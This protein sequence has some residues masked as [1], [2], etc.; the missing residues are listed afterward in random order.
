MAWPPSSP[1][2]EPILPCL[3]S[4]LI[5]SSA[6]RQRQPI[7]ILRDDSAGDVDLL[8]LDSGV[9]RVAILA[10]SVHGPELRADH[11][12]LQAV[13]IRVSRR[14]FTKIVDIDI[15]ARDGVF[16]NSPWQVVVAIDQRGLAENPFCPSEINIF[17]WG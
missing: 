11:S 17:G 1:S 7:G 16:A 14:A 12:L 6:E 3:K 5:S 15:P 2:S 4:R 10:G 13:E 9:T 8:E